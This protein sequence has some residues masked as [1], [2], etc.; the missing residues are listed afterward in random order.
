LAAFRKSARRELA[1]NKTCSARR[2]RIRSGELG[3]HLMDGYV[4][5][6]G[7]SGVSKSDAEIAE[8]DVVALLV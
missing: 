1:A 7:T 3:E 4:G 5:S 8:E 2:W 6:Q